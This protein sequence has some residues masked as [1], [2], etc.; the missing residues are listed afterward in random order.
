MY[1]GE[2]SNDYLL[3]VLQAEGLLTQEERKGRWI[4][5]GD[6]NKS[7]INATIASQDR[8]RKSR[9]KDSDGR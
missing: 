7:S 5:G 4:S 6:V 8:E 9:K 2:A 1:I 3:E